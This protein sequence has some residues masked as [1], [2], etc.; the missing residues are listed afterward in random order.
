MIEF[1]CEEHDGK[2]Y[3][4][5]SHGDDEVREQVHYSWRGGYTVDNI[6][7][8]CDEAARGVMPVWCPD[9]VPSTRGWCVS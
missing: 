1:W 4:H 2:L 9:P 7:D 5:A 8:A 6:L 3:V